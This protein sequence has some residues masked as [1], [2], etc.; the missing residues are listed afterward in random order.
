MIRLIKRYESRK[1]YDT[2]E[3]RYV[4]LDEIAEWIRTGQE[5][6]V[7][8]NGTGADVTAQTLTQIILDEGTKGTAL[9]PTRAAARAGPGRRARRS[10]PASS[11][12]STAST[13]CS[14]PRS[15]GSGRCAGRARRWSQ[16]RERLEELESSLE[17]LE[18]D[19]EPALAGMARAKT[20]RPAAR[21]ASSRATRDGAA[22]TGKGAGR[23]LPKTA[24]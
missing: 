3:S 2:E 23:K 19:R 16:L 18:R 5:V 7:V 11:R 14:R 12:S 8:D 1:L 9:L 20:P 6:Q 13:V 17:A 22:S 24:S 21:A 15:T 4:S 10:P